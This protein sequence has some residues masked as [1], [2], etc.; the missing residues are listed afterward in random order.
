MPNTNLGLTSPN[1]QDKNYNELLPAMHRL[2]NHNNFTLNILHEA[3][4][5]PFRAD[6]DDYKMHKSRSCHVQVWHVVYCIMGRML[7]KKGWNGFTYTKFVEC[8]M[9]KYWFFTSPCKLPKSCKKNWQHKIG[10]NRSAQR[11]YHDL[12][13]SNDWSHTSIFAASICL[14]K[15]YNNIAV[16]IQSFIWNK[17]STLQHLPFELL[18]DNIGKKGTN[19]KYVFF[20]VISSFYES[21]H[22]LWTKTMYWIFLDVHS[23]IV[24]LLFFMRSTISRLTCSICVVFNSIIQETAIMFLHGPCVWNRKWIGIRETTGFWRM[25][26]VLD[27]TILKLQ[28]N[29]L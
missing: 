4:P 17:E 28:P 8:S 5:F 16:K 18:L 21:C 7:E 3:I 25:T 12:G 9:Q 29:W 24:L 22:I 23:P 20:L 27:K 26:L 11:Y 10:Q 14:F 2:P 6:C 19:L 13:G 15:C 1:P